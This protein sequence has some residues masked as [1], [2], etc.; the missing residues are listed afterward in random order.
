[1]A[2]SML[3]FVASQVHA[4]V[5]GIRLL[6]FFVTAPLGLHA[7][8]KMLRES[9]PLAESADLS[10]EELQQRRTAFVELTDQPRELALGVV[11][12]VGRSLDTL[13]L[14]TG[15]GGSPFD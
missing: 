9:L 10:R 15:A 2:A 7:D 8:I 4:V 6:E 5:E 3:P 1:M 13:A 14:S 11:S 12:S